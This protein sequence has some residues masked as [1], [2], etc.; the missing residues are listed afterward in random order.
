[1]IERQHEGGAPSELQ[2]ELCV[3]AA[4]VTESAAQDIARLVERVLER[5]VV[6][7]DAAVTEIY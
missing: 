4:W 5:M 6:G 7:V 3:R 2:A 1:V